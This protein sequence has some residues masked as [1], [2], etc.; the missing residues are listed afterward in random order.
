METKTTSAMSALA[1]VSDDAIVVIYR[2]GG[3]ARFRWCMMSGT[4]ASRE[5]AQPHVE[6]IERMGYPVRVTTKRSMRHGLP[7]SW[8][9]DYPCARD[10]GNGWLCQDELVTQ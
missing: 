8:S 5:D 1:N 3:Y 2:Q 10:T 7:E 9:K 6:E 4:F